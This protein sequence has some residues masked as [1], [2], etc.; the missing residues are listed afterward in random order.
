MSNLRPARTPA[1]HTETP[2]T[3]K[4]HAMTDT[5]LYDFLD[6]DARAEID[7]ERDASAAAFLAGLRGYEARP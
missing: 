7:A 5:D 1:S 6:D 4:E 3:T 2:T